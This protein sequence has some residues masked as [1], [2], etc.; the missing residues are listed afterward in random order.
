MWKTILLKVLTCVSLPRGTDG[1]PLV[2]ISKFPNAIC[3]WMFGKTL[4]DNRK[5]ITNA[6]VG[7]VCCIDNLLVI[8]VKLVDV[9]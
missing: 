9:L 6:M 2:A 1:K 8:I 5:E 7:I 4:A 3:K